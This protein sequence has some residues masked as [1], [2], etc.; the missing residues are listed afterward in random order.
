MID[1]DAPAPPVLANSPE[2]GRFDSQ[3]NNG[4]TL[5]ALLVLKHLNR[6]PKRSRPPSPSE[7][8]AARDLDAVID[9]MIGEIAEGHQVE[10][11]RWPWETG[12]HIP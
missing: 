1:Q 4:H 11:D 3:P 8:Q 5:Y 2:A 6:N 9:D 10:R 7:A 12:A